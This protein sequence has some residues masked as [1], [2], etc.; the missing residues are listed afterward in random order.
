MLNFRSLYRHAEEHT[1][2]MIGS[3]FFL[4]A[5]LLLLQTLFSPTIVIG[6]LLVIGG[7]V[8]TFVRPLWV[9]GFLALYLPFESFLLK[10]APD[11]LYVL[12]R[13]A[14]EGLIYLL[15]AVVLFRVLLRY[16]KFPSS[17]IDLPFVLFLLT[18]ITSIVV[19]F[20]SPSIAILGT[21]QI[22]RFILVFFLVLFFKPSKQYIRT[23]TFLL[24][25]VVFFECGLGIMQS[26]IGEPLDLLL[27]PSE[28]R[29]FGD[30]TLTSGVTP[31]WDPGTR[32][33]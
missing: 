21:R 17:P 2:H 16:Q 6:G 32:I 7:V 23:L 10:F 24:F 33:F 27:L 12:A 3:L 14:S 30:I 31:N 19:N 25:G 8:L 29:S 22:I 28:A 13:Y 4:L 18:I 11:E 1:G 9:L 5:I 20:V 15:V 26:F